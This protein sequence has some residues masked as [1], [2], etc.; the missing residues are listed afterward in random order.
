MSATAYEVMLLTNAELED[1][2]RAAVV[3]RLKQQVV[4][5]GGTVGEMTDWGRRKLAYEI[6]KQKEAFYTL[7]Y[8]DCDGDTLDEAVHLLRITD[9][10]LRVM[11][12]TRVAPLA[13]GVELVGITDEEAAAPPA[14][15]GRGGRGGGG[16][17]GRGR[18]RER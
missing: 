2:A 13:E 4:K 5:G 3:E 14:R 8:V 10:V 7:A 15:G 11:A 1:E 6:A 18:D 9:G 17:G 12:V 16:G